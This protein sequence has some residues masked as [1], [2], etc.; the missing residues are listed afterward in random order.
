[1]PS[2]TTHV[3]A[4]G[5]RPTVPDIPYPTHSHDPNDATKTPGYVYLLNPAIG[6]QGTSRCHSADYSGG[7]KNT[8]S[9]AAAALVCPG[10]PTDKLI[11]AYRR[12]K[13]LTCK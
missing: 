10:A 2:G 11:T 1:M 9:A 12:R 4:R 13:Y 6:L 7:K 3:T 5:A 8:S